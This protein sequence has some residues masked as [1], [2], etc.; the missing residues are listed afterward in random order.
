[1]I[2]RNPVRAMSPS[3]FWPSPVSPTTPDA[4]SRSSR[5]T[6]PSTWSS[7]AG[8]ASSPPDPTYEVNDQ[9]VRA[10]LRQSASRIR[11]RAA[12]PFAGRPGV[13]GAAAAASPGRAGGE[14]DRRDGDRGRVVRGLRGVVVRVASVDGREQ[15]LLARRLHALRQSYKPVIGSRT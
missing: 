12:A 4:P 5:S 15:P 3:R 10:G 1:P 9:H 7:A 14:G 2:V 6:C 11:L 8:S 13:R